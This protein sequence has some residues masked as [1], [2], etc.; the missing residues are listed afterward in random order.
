M[1]LRLVFFPIF[2]V[3][4]VHAT[5]CQQVAGSCAR[6]LKFLESRYRIG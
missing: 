2:W 6:A 5:G 4:D 3:F 1:K